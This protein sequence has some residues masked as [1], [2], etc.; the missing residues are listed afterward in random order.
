MMKSV[1]FST[2]MAAGAVL[3]MVAFVLLDPISGKKKRCIRKKSRN[4]A[5][6]IGTAMESFADMF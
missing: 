6:A 1:K 2:G 4:V 5:K 3:G